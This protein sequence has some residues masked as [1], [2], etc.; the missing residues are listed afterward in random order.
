MEDLLKKAR[1]FAEPILK[2]YVCK[3]TGV[4]YIQA[5]DDIL[6]LHDGCASVYLFEVHVAGLVTFRDLEVEFGTT[7]AID[8]HFYVIHERNFVHSY[9]VDEYGFESLKVGFVKKDEYKAP[10]HDEAT[11]EIFEIG[12]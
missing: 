7:F 9:V 6:D 5:L 4:P 2:D 12:E 3:R 1:A 11:F 10:A 8:C